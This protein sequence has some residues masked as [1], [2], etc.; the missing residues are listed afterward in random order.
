MQSVASELVKSVR[1]EEKKNC[2]LR[3][4]LEAAA[5]H[6]TSSLLASQIKCM[7]DRLGSLDQKLGVTSRSSNVV[8]WLITLGGRGGRRENAD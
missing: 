2:Q 7:F 5:D 8:S 3:V 1:G 4:L 6:W